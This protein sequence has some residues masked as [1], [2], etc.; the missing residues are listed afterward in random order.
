VIE[1]IEQRRWK[2]MR[3][4]AGTIELAGMVEC[5]GAFFIASPAFYDQYTPMIVDPVQALFNT[6]GDAAAVLA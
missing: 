1:R 3:T 4:V 6:L 5:V 2:V